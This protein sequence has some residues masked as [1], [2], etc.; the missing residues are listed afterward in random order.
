MVFMGRGKINRCSVF[1]LIV[2]SLMLAPASRAA[3]GMAIEYGHGEDS[4]RM[5]RVVLIHPWNR[6]W[7]T[8]GNWY[9][10]G[11]WEASVG[12]WHS[13]ASG[14]KT[15]W[16]LG[17]TPVFRLQT[18]A[19]S[20]WRPYVEGAIGVHVLSHTHVNAE[21][22]LG[23]AFQFGDHLGVGLVFG[24]RGQFDLGYR[25]QHLSNAGIQKRNDGID[26]QQLRFTYRF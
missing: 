17:L 25:F 21:R 16:D 6:Q 2:S 14:G 5:G 22:D 1:A 3:G 24:D 10:T 4:T 20:G 15:L 7:F 18:R 13:S 8:G 26:F 19:D 9:L 11:Y 12:R 23:S